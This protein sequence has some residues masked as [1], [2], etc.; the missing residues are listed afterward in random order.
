MKAIMFL[1][2]V[3]IIMIHIVMINLIHRVTKFMLYNS[4][5]LCYKRTEVQSMILVLLLE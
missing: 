1:N 5:S 3:Y 2:I 4:K